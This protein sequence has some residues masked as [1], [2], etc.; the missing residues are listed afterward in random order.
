V[1]VRARVSNSVLLNAQEYV[2]QTQSSNRLVSPARIRRAIALVSITSLF[3]LHGCVYIGG[4]CGWRGGGGWHHG[5]RHCQT[6]MP[7]NVVSM[8]TTPTATPPGAAANT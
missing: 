3:A 7:S 8:N 2:M 6:S 5:G 1:I 4:G